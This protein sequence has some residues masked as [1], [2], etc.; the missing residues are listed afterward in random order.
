MPFLTELHAH[1]AESSSCAHLSAAE[2]AER[3]LAAGYRTVT[4]TNHYNAYNLDLGG[5]SWEDRISHHLKGYRAMKEYAGDRLCVLLGCELRF[6]ENSND[7]LILGLTEE[8]LWNYPELQNMT[9]RSFSELA[10]RLGLLIVQAHPF[11][12][13]MTVMNPRYLDGIEVFNGHAEH[14]SRN[15]IALSWA[16]LQGLIPTSGTD[17][18]DP[19]HTPCG[20]IITEAPILS[21]EDLIRTLKSG[22]YTLHCAGAAAERDGMTDLPANDK[23]GRHGVF[24]S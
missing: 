21:M 11:R 1:T 5:T 10:H 7:Y 16:R 4:V 19:E 18:H 22:S 17:F 20:G 2:V 8:I 9:L 24:K 13:G 12:N 14:Q 15:R 6:T 3:Y 23:G